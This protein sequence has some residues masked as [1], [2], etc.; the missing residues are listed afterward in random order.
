MGVVPIEV[1]RSLH[2]QNRLKVVGRCAACD[3]A[4]CN[5]FVDPDGPMVYFGGLSIFEPSAVS[6]ADDG[7]L[8][9]VCSRSRCAAVFTV[10][11]EVA[12]LAAQDAARRG[13][14]VVRLP[15]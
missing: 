4:L 7:A 11:L 12:I 5:F 10:P 8:R 9:F 13:Q 2:E 14:R 3:K 15:A 6:S 1:K